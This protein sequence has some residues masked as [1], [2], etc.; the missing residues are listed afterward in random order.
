MALTLAAV[1]AAEREDWPDLNA[2]LADREDCISN[3]N[4]ATWTDDDRKLVQRADF[5]GR[6]LAAKMSHELELADQD[7]VERT[8]AKS[9]LKSFKPETI[10][11][12]Y[13]FQS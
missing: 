2:I 10:A 9:K 1:D 4:P 12:G 8:R 5:L 3:L 6:D 7:K 13:D 11:V